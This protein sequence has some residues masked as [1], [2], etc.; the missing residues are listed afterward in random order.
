MKK[1]KSIILIITALLLIALGNGSLFAQATLKEIAGKV[2]VKAPGAAWA[3]AWAGMWIGPG[4]MIATGFN[5]KATIDLDNSTLY[6]KQLTRLTI[7]EIARRQGVVYTN[8]KINTGS[9]E[10]EIKDVRD[11]GFSHDF[12]VRSPVSTAAVRGCIIKYN[13]NVLLVKE[14]KATL[15]NILGQ[16]TTVFMGDSA[17]TEDGLDLVTAKMLKELRHRVRILPLRFLLRGGGLGFDRSNGFYFFNNSTTV[18]FYF[19]WAAV[20]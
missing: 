14:G 15:F 11:Q 17:L 5:S 13:G 12:K 4:S 10:A 20:N 2:E 18:T 16:P 3:A 6:V 19:D 1:Y 8:L 7:E 9:L